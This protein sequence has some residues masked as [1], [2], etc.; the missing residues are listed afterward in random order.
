M[1][2]PPV[3]YLIPIFPGFQLLDLTGPLDILNLLSI[4]TTNSELRLTFISETLD[5]VPTKPIPPAVADWSF[6]LETAFPHTKGKVNTTFNE[7]LQPDTTYA[8]YLKALETGEN[9][10]PVDVLL[11]PGGIG[12]RLA[13]VHQDGSKTSNIKSL[14]DFVPQVA[15][16]IRTAI[17]TVCTGSDALA[18]TGLL[19]NRRATT[20][21]ARFAE[22]AQ[23]NPNVLWQHAARWVRSLPSE[24]PGSTP[25]EIWSS[26]GIS[27]G[28]D[29]T[30]AFIAHFYGGRD[31]ARGLAKSLEYD[32]REIAEGEKD[33]LYEKYYMA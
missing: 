1:A 30:L 11:I 29:V 23:R 12:T 20:N 19:H 27:A 15:P 14:L 2:P 13:R 22:V 5:P 31:V 18:Q 33:P 24:A 28:M 17:I 9:S 16:H 26:A 6:D 25:I 3:H 10:Q 7:Y 21:M 8:E 4:V 32:W